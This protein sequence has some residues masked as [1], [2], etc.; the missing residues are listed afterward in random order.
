M[1]E[2]ER[3][4]VDET[5]D[6]VDPATAPPSEGA[7][8]AVADV[9]PV[10]EEPRDPVSELRAEYDTLNDRHLR[11]AAEFTNFKRRAEQESLGTW[12]RAQADLVRR[13]LDVLDDLQRVSGLDPADEATTVES[14][15]EGIDLVER[16]FLRTLQDA[17]VEVISPEEGAPFDPEAMEAM[18]R[19]PTGDAD[20]D[21][22][23]AMCFQKGYGLDGNLIRPARV[24]VYKAD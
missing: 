17:G 15:V 9:G 8:G 21:D 22:H 4:I 11:L 20:Q 2:N 6:P 14:I 7:D 16:K 1:S 24:S 23:V 19:V 12:A 5:S 3:P 18:M 10:P 13:F